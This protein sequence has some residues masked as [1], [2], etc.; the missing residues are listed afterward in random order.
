MDWAKDVAVVKL[1][2]GG[3]EVVNF[4]PRTPQ[5]KS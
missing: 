5:I 3:L 1:P 2:T 4:D